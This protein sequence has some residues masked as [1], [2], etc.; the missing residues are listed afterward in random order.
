MTLDLACFSRVMERKSVQ[1]WGSETVRMML[2]RQWLARARE[3]LSS[4]V[5]AGVV[6]SNG[7]EAG[8]RWDERHSE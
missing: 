3:V 6:L 1:R 4:G 8:E 7:V 2:S 5:E